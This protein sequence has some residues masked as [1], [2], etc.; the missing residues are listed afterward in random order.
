MEGDSTMVLSWLEGG[1]LHP[2]DRKILARL[3]VVSFFLASRSLTDSLARF[4]MVCGDVK[5]WS[6]AYPP[7][8]NIV[9]MLDLPPFV[10]VLTVQ[11]ET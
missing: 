10:G 1:C 5:T 6:S 3:R 11:P 8:P 7:D 2:G 9:R 4:G